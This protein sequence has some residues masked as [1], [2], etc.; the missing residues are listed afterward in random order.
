MKRVI[1]IGILL[2]MLSLV[3]AC[4]PEVMQE[5]NDEMAKEDSIQEDDMMEKHEDS[6]E[7]KSMDEKMMEMPPSIDAM[8]KEPSED[9]M[10]MEFSQSGILV[11]VTNGKDVR[12]INTNDKASGIAQAI[13]KDGEYNLLATF[14]NLPDPVGTDFYEGWI[15]RTG[16]KFDVISS[17]KLEKVD[18]QYVNKYSSAQ[19]L[20]GHKFYVLTIEPDD[21]NSAPADHVVEGTME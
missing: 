21:G 18:G 12:G 6:M 15:V 11:D 3:V 19:D 4:T 9:M 17:G 10:A 14:E 16:L 1:L 2:V 7:E 8:A 5:T 13:F 20:T